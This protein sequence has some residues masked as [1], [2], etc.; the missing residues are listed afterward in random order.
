MLCGIGDS[1]LGCCPHRIA[2]GC[3]MLMSTLNFIW[4]SEVLLQQCCVLLAPSLWAELWG[5]LTGL[6]QSPPQLLKAAG[7]F[8]AVSKATAHSC[9]LTVWGIWWQ[10]NYK[11]VVCPPAFPWDYTK[12]I[13]ESWKRIF[14]LNVLQ[15]E[16][17]YSL[18][19]RNGFQIF[20]DPYNQEALTRV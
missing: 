5:S 6:G 1:D 14:F 19:Q 18:S 11:T 17:F 12:A 13:L 8:I 2:V 7:V 15:K 10:Q 16:S 4:P 9:D 20:L 3:C